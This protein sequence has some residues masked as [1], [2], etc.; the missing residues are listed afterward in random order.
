MTKVAADSVECWAAD[1]LVTVMNKF[2]K[3]G[4]Q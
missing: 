4:S 1:G 2:N 3:S